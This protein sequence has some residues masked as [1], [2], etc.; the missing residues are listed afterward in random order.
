MRPLPFCQGRL[1]WQ[2]SAR[3]GGSSYKGVGPGMQGDVRC[4]RSELCPAVL[5]QTLRQPLL[6]DAPGREEAAGSSAWEVC[7][8]PAHA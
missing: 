1:P 2:N 7:R 3:A 8:Q 5:P 6:G 4:Q